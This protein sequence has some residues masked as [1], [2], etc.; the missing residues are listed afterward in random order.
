MDLFKLLLDRGADKR[1][2]HRY[3][4]FISNCAENTPTGISEAHHILPKSMFPEF[5][6]LKRFTWNK[7]ILTPRQHF[8]AHWMLWKMFPNES[9]QSFAFWNMG[10]RNKF[11]LY[12]SRLYEALKAKHTEIV[13]S[14][15]KGRKFSAESKAKMSRSHMGKVLTISH[16]E[17]ISKYQRENADHMRGLNNPVHTHGHPRLGV[18]LLEETKQKMSKSLLAKPRVTCPHCLKDGASSIMK[19]WHFDRCRVKGPDAHET[20]KPVS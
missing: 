18:T 19:R 16:R 8:L 15:L 5:T 7:A 12:S 6:S 9:S 20:L 14:K 10:N 2:L 1:Q 11:K 4:S 3:L 17:N 13:S